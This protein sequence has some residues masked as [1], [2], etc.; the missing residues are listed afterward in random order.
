MEQPQFLHSR[1]AG[2]DG[3]VMPAGR[4]GEEQ[5]AEPLGRDERRREQ[6]QDGSEE[7]PVV[8]HNQ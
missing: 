8:I 4:L 5:N 7:N 3:I 6:G 2:I 1:D